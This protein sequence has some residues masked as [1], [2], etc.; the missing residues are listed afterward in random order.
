MKTL[1]VLTIGLLMSVATFA[2]PRVEFRERVVCRPAVCVHYVAPCRHYDRF[3]NG[4]GHRECRERAYYH[5][6]CGRRW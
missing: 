3:D 6:R 1:L 4:Y 5:D 2:R